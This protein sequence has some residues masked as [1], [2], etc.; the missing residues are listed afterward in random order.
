MFL[1]TGQS[2]SQ[3]VLILRFFVEG[4]GFL[5]LVGYL[6]YN[7]IWFG[8]IFFPFLIHHV[9]TE[10]QKHEHKRQ[11]RIAIEFKDGMQAVVS[12]LT[13]GYS[14]E[15][16]FREALDEINVVY[17][18]NT[19][20]YKGFSKIVYRLNLNTNI[21]DAFDDFAEECKVEEINNFAEILHYAKRSGGNLIQI[22][23][24]TTDTISEKID[25]KREIN[26]IISSKQLEQS[27][28]NYVPIFI[29]LYMRITSPEMFT[30]I[31]GNLA[32]TVIMSVCLCVYFV[33]R[34]IAG[35]IVNIHV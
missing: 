7:N 8:L 34:I 15:N 12:A 31:Y 18:R 33:A 27:I 32:G 13:A 5:L 19:D 14:L 29:I 30:N 21:E 35:K 3:R 16:S 1:G 28:M 6:F 4:I 9:K 17:G 11:E 10:L 23:K 26:T 2:L 22:I 24:N 20:I 25:V